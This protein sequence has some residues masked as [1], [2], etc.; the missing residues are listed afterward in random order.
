MDPTMRAR[1]DA[2]RKANARSKDMDG[3]EFPPDPPPGVYEA[4][5]QT[6]KLFV[7]STGKPML[8]RVFII[9]G[10]DSHGMQARDFLNLEQDFLIARM[11]AFVESHGYDMPEE[12]FDY[13]AC[14]QEDT[15]VFV[16]EAVDIISAIEGENREYKIE[17]SQR[18]V[19]DR[20]FNSV[21]ILEVGDAEEGAPKPGDKPKD[22]EPDEAEAT[23]DDDEGGGEDDDDDEALRTELLAFCVDEGGVE[24]AKDDMDL[25]TLKGKIEEYVF[26]PDTITKAQ[27]ATNKDLKGEDPKDGISADAVELLERA[28]LGSCVFKPK[29]APAEKKTSGGRKR[30]K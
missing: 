25:E 6:A 18:I 20:A 14:E 21:A 22:E 27:L 12:L 9:E 3:G 24:E 5:I 13:D 26:W 19:G 30:S 10:G 29:K 15:W 23:E 28:G 1:I 4:R 7:S 2:A 16:P 8:Q 17:F 11:R